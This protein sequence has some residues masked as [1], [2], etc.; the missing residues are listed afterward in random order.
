MKMN[1]NISSE[2]AQQLQTNLDSAVESAGIAGTTVAVI[3]S[4]GTW[5]GASGVSN[6]ETEKPLNPDELFKIGSISK[7]FTSATI[8]KLVEEEKLNLQDTLDKWLPDSIVDNVPNAKDIN[9][10]QLLNHTSGIANYTN[11]KWF[12][13]EL[14]F[15]N[16]ADVDWSREAIINNYVAGENPDFAPGES[17]NYSNTNYLLLGMLIEAA[18]SNS[19]QD[20]V[21]RLIL[22]PLGL[23]NTYFVGDKIPED[24]F[25]NGYAD[26][27]GED[28]SFGSDGILEETKNSFSSLAFTLADGAIISNTKDVSRFSN[29]LFGG[30]L[31]TPESLNHMLSWSNIDEREVEVG[32]DYGLGIYE[33]LTP[34]GEI[35][36]HDGGTFGYVSKMQYFPEKD[37]TIVILTNQASDSLPSAIDSIFSAVNNTLFGEPNSNITTEE[38]LDSLSNNF[39]NDLIDV[40]NGIDSKADL[41]ALIN[42]KNKLA[43]L[44]DDDIDGEKFFQL[45]TNPDYADDSTKLQKFLKFGG[46]VPE[47]SDVIVGNEADNTLAGEERNDTIAGGLGN[48]LIFG[49]GGD[50]VL[51]GDLNNSSGGGSVGGDDTIYGGMGNDRIGGKAG[52]DLIFGEAGKDRLW[53]D[54]GDDTL[55]GGLGNDSLNGGAGKDVFVLKLN[56]GTDKVFDFKVD[57]DLIDITN[58]GVG[59]EDIDITQEGKDAVITLDGA[60]IAILQDVNADSLSEDNF[61]SDDSSGLSFPEPTGEYSVGTADYYFQDLEREEIY[62]EDPDDN[63]ELTVKVWYPTEISEGETAPYLSEE[64]SRELASGFGLSE[65]ELIELNKQ[66]STNSIINAPVADTESD[67][68]VLLFSHGF[69]TPSEF[70]T[71]NGE[72]LASQ[73]YVVVSM[74]HTYDA[75]LTVFPDGRIVGQSPVFNVQNEAEFLEAARQSV[76]VRAED[77]Q[78]V[79]DELEDINAGEGLLSGKLD[80]DNVGFLGYS[81]GGATAAETL[82][83]DDRFKAGINLDGSL[84]INRVDESL[85]QPFMFMN[86]DVFGVGTPTDPLSKELQEIRE[87]FIKN[88]QNDGYQLTIDDTNHQSFSDIPIFL[89]QLKD[90]GVDLGDLEN[91]IAPIDPERA[92]TIINDYTVAFFDKYLNNEDSPLLVADNSTYPEVTFELLETGGSINQEPIFGTVDNDVIEVED[93]NKIIFAGKGNDLID[94]SNSSEGDNRIY[95]GEGD[96]ILILGKDSRVFGEAG[97]DRFFATSGGN[98]IVTGGEG[99]DQF[100]VAVAETPDAANAITD[101]TIGEDVIGIAGL[102]IGFEDISITQQNDNTLIAV[103]GMGLG[104]LQ[105]IDANVLSVENFVIV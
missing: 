26:L 32:D 70:T 45:F 75:P 63:R 81:L 80:L 68:P 31:L 24:R 56:E 36:G 66:I 42:D 74:N 59:L 54:A 11:Q 100:W 83:Q 44:G 87:S 65:E 38:W 104:I 22:E 99:A 29:A 3:N 21:N 8:L 98:N 58:L 72:E 41:I 93:S 55:I 2:L 6:L 91:F 51:R 23:E 89:N 95:G 33:E 46:I 76:G 37:T 14:A 7:T 86:S 57:D 25:V 35:W 53:G 79:L 60:D 16:G 67:Y 9:I 97:N 18:T 105:G 92:T 27:I 71:T 12:A 61:V 40:V 96:D 94:A 88:M 62:T 77:A 34:W 78:F 103:D 1:R 5:F 15:Q 69:G 47:E 20:E 30:E 28:G 4:E 48:D 50:D 13:D 90:S 73:G 43:K 84:L 49:Q 39:V 10:E 101:F 85:S 17:F 82:L 19:Y 102:G 52:N 64:L